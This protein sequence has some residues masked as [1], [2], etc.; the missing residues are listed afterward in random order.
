MNLDWSGEI[1]APLC[2]YETR[3]KP[4][5]IDE[6]KHVNIAHYLTI[7]DQSN[8]NFWNWINHPEGTMEA[9]AGREY[10]IVEN[11]VHYIDELSLDEPIYVTTQ[12][13]GADDKRYVLF[14]RVH[15]AADDSL[16]A[17]NEVKCLGF[18]LEARRI[19]NWRAPVRARLGA[20]L[21]AHESLGWPEQAGQGIALKRRR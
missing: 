14:H 20:I 8:W 13:L 18:N 17:T 7:C 12:L 6:F 15:K 21:A 2:L 4:E 5:W 19:E 1:A 16:S 3:V 9:R 10:V 11:H